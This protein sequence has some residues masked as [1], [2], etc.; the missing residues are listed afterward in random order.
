MHTLNADDFN[1]CWGFM[2]CCLMLFGAIMNTCYYDPNFG[3]MF[4]IA[5]FLMFLVMMA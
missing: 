1:A 4:V 2:A 5:G 3:F